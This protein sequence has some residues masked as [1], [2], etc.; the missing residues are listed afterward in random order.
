[1]KQQSAD[2]TLDKVKDYYGRVLK[3]TKDLKTTACCVAESI[4]IHLRDLVRNIHPEVTDRFYGC[5]STFPLELKG[6]TVLDLGCGSGRDVYLLSQLVG[7]SGQVYGIDMTDEQ[8]HVAKKHQDYHRQ[9]FGYQKSNVHLVTGFIEDLESAGIASNSIDVIVSNCVINL[10]PEKDRVFSEIFRVLKPGGELHFS[11]VFCDRRLPEW[12]REDKILL[13]ECLGGAMYGQD[14]RRSLLK[15]GFP[16]YRIVKS[17]PIEL[18]DTEVVKK[19]GFAK[20]SSITVRAFKIESLEDKCEDYGQVAF[21]KGTISESPH[22]FQL[23]D[24]HTFHKD[25]PLLI[26]SNTASMLMETRYRDHFRVDGNLNNHYGLF[27]CAPEEM[28]NFQAT[29]DSAAACC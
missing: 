13:G 9:T 15:A 6:K 25:R 1:M 23:D 19:V 24:H 16:D 3:S 10:S 27:D 21:Y 11:D 20:F 18:T 22:S 2:K 28:K 14:F 4:P 12:C 7:Q 26:C 17:S 29:K 5:G 8:L